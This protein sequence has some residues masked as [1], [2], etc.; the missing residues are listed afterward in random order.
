MKKKA[1]AARWFIYLVGMIV[2]ALGLILN[3]EAG[4][5][6]SAIMSVAYTCLLYTSRCV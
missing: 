5:G 3:I 4:L 2:L 1:T 6:S